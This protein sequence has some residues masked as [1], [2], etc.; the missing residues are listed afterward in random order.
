[1]KDRRSG[2]RAPT[3]QVTSPD[4]S[5]SLTKKKTKQ[6][7]KKNRKVKEVLSWSRYQREEQRG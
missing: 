5:P 6:N 1:M 2:N 3:L 4:S 7:K